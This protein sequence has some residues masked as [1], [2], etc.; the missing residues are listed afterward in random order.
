M[1]IWVI[2]FYWPLIGEDAP[3]IVERSKLGPIILKC[4][5]DISFILKPVIE[6]KL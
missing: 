1:V 2:G 6:Y 5:P 4:L 3:A